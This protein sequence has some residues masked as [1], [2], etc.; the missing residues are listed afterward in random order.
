MH[1][2]TYTYTHTC[3]YVCMCLCVFVYVP[4]ITAQN[5]RACILVCAHVCDIETCT[6]FSTMHFV[7]GP[8]VSFLAYMYV[9]IA[10]YGVCMFPSYV[11]TYARICVC[12]CHL[13]ECVCVFIYTYVRT[14]EW[15]GDV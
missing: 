14:H 5:G 3:I 9:C 10:V 1:T 13:Y 4:L 7:F 6:V 12:V 2:Y 15:Y 11:R 8:L